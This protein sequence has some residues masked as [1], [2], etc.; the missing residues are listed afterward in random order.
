MAYSETEDTGGLTPAKDGNEAVHHF[1]RR[2]LLIFN[3]AGYTNAAHTC[4]WHFQ[5]PSANS[6]CFLR[7]KLFGL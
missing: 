3:F 2:T 4:R 7:P 1:I 6:T 5:I